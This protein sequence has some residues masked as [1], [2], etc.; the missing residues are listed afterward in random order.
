MRLGDTCGEWTA[1]KRGCLQGSLL[2]PLLWNIYQNDLFYENIQSQL[3]AYVD[4]HQIY[5]RD[6]KINPYTQ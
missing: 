3:G 1:V 5:I 6:E 4:D 2:S